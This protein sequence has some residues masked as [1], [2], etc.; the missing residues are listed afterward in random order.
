MPQTHWR[1]CP[2]C[3]ADRPRTLPRYGDGDWRIAAC[4]D[5]GFAYVPR[6]PDYAELTDAFAWEKTSEAEAGRRQTRWPR[7]RHTLRRLRGVTRRFRRD[8]AAVLR[9]ALPSGAVLDVG[10]GNGD[11]VPEGLTP[12]G[13][14]VSRTLAE[15][16]QAAMQ[17]RGG[18]VVHAPALE[19]V[20]AFPDDSFDGIILRS[21][22]E[23]EA[24]PR[25]VLTA[26]YRKL[27]PGG[28]AFVRV[29]N[30]GSLNAAVMGPRWCGVRLPDHLN[31]FTS[32]QL[33]AM[34]E[35]AGFA[36]R[37]L[38]RANLPVDD[39]IKCLLHKPR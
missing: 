27:K 12:Y 39:N 32:R 21:Y 7:L 4:A 36:Y 2:R 22:L 3:G 28:A 38:N 9:R 26:A 18:R 10:C 24:Q 11:R 16:A 17:A 14:E 23:H 33:R 5:C 25:A 8:E 35:E 1:V 37:L 19:G 29:P 31:Y 15:R 34:A 6:A 13:I 20:E 30:F